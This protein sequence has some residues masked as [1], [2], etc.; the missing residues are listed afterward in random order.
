MY[1]N[2]V[3]CINGKK[4]PINAMHFFLNNV[5]YD[6]VNNYGNNNRKKKNNNNKKKCFRTTGS[7]VKIWGFDN[8]L[9]QLQ[10]ITSLVRWYNFYIEIPV[11]TALSYVYRTFFYFSI[12]SNTVSDFNNFYI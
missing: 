12:Y 2:H 7:D 4:P 8:D 10:I 5:R 6:N 11:Q 1:Y 3:P 9:D